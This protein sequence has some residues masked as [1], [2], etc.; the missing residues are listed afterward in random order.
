MNLLLVLAYHSMW[1]QLALLIIALIA[2]RDYRPLDILLLAFGF[3]AILTVVIAA[4][5]PAI[6][7]LAYLEITSSDHPDIKLAVPRECCSPS[8]SRAAIILST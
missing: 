3:G 6:S 1:P 5:M 8:R 2:V 7:P 4:F